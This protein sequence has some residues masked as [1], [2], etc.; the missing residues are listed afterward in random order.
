MDVGITDGFD[1]VIGNPPYIKEAIN[2]NAF[3]GLRK[4]DCYQ[5]K[6]DLWYLFGAKD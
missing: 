6:M 3:D 4:S 5:G 1:V 2:K